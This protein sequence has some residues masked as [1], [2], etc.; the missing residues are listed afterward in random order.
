MIHGRSHYGRQTYWIRWFHLCGGKRNLGMGSSDVSLLPAHSRDM[1]PMPR[2][3]ACRKLKEHNAL[4]AG[5]ESAY[6]KA[7][8]QGQMTEGRLPELKQQ[9]AQ[10][11]KEAEQ[12]AQQARHHSDGKPAN[13][14]SYNSNSSSSTSVA[15]KGGS[16]LLD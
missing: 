14:L 11:E 4:V 8:E 3:S 6:N 5:H 9:A 13:C 12:A 15:R 10:A 2:H 1:G 16:I 7:R